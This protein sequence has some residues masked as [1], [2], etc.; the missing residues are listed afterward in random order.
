MRGAMNHRCRGFNLLLVAGTR[1]YPISHLPCPF[2]A[3]S[4]L[5]QKATVAKEVIDF[6]I[7]LFLSLLLAYFILDEHVL[8]VHV[9]RVQCDIS[10]HVHISCDSPTPTSSPLRQASGS[11]AI[12]QH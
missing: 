8:I 5:L 11:T 4:S 3:H 7:Y 2:S 6:F 10:I 1:A 12:W 9:S